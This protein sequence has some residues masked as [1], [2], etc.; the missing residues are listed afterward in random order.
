VNRDYRLLFAIRILRSFGFGFIAVLLGLRLEQRGLGAAQLGVALSIAVLAA[1][2][3]GLPA[4]SLA[5]RFGRRPVLTVLGL[6]M[7]LSGADLGLAT[8]PGL[9]LLAGATG[10]LGATGVDLGPFLAIEQAILVESVPQRSR[11]R[12]FGRY[13]LTG[14]LGLSVGGLAASYGSSPDR[15]HQLFLL[16]GAIGV[17]TAVISLMLSGH[18]DNMAP[19]PILS[20]T[21]IK[22]VLRLAGLFAV[23]ALAGGLVL[24]AVIA[25]WLHV[26]FGAGSAILGPSFAAIALIQAGSYEVASRLADRIGLVRT[27]V[28]TQLPSNILLMILPFSA[29]LAMALIVL[30]LRFSIAQMDVPARQAYVASIVPPSE[31]TGALALTG[32]VRGMSQA[33]GPVI[34]GLAIQ[35]AAIGVPFFLAGLLKVAYDFALYVAFAQR[36]A[37]HE[38]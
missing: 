38:L 16:F 8:Q 17:F 11:N 34:A 14:G 3:Y 26:R 19:G 20:R 1:S 30:F 4:A 5:A 15:V 22:P 28:F 25:Y 24:Q 13:S 2:L 33:V 18:V 21:S 36:P 12:A 27:M 23:D 7:A 32:T 35:S 37:G 9:L 29:N 10:M 6:L 31:R